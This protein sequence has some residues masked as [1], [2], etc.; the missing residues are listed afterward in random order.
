MAIKNAKEILEHDQPPRRR[1]EGGKIIQ[2][3]DGMGHVAPAV[4]GR[5]K[6]K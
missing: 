5:T 1:Q 3:A 4:T 2:T 6:H